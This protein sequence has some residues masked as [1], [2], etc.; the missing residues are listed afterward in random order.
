MN[1]TYHAQG[2]TLVELMIVVGIVGLLA[3]VA[4][5]SYNGYIKTSQNGAAAAQGEALAGFEDTYFYENDTYLDGS[6][7]PGVA[8]DLTAKLDWKPADKDQFIYV[9]AGGAD[10]GGNITKC[11]TITVTLKSDPSISQS[12]SRP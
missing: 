9:V 4:V 6:Y 1:K 11:Y 2:W 12:I 5:P 8:D 10:C 7:N 3:T